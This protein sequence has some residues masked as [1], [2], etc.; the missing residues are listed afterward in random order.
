MRPVRRNSCWAPPATDEFAR[1]G[2]ANRRCLTGAADAG[3]TCSVAL[4][5]DEASAL[6]VVDFGA[7][8]SVLEAALVGFLSFGASA[9]IRLTSSGSTFCGLGAA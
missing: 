3:A 9:S 5:S 6:T 1:V 4:S 7:G 8:R 2:C